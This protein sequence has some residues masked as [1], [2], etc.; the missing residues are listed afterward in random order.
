M[1][2]LG[3]AT[4]VSRGLD[5]LASLIAIALLS[6]EAMGTAALVLSAGR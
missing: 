5:V 2:W 4:A 3:S 6:R 1:L